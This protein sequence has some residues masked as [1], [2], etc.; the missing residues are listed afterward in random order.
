MKIQNNT[1]SFVEY[2][3]FDTIK[4]YISVS[5]IHSIDIVER[6]ANRFSHNN[7]KYD[8]EIKT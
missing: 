1:L 2:R 8:L 5:D 4:K 6:G 3:V 7:L